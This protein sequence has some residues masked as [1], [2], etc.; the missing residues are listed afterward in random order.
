MATDHCNTV[1]KRTAQRPRS[2]RRTTAGLIARYRYTLDLH[3]PQTSRVGQNNYSTTLPYLKDGL[4]VW[5][6]RRTH[7]VLQCNVAALNE[8]RHGSSLPV[9]VLTIDATSCRA[10]SNIRPRDNQKTR[11]SLFLR[12]CTRLNRV[13]ETPFRH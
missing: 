9:F 2:D 7:G 3:V 4:Q 6:L 10:I 12:Q 8:G 5:F 11:C 13:L 1:A